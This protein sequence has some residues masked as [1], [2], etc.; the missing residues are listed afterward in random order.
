[1]IE[2]KNMWM[3]EVHLYQKYNEMKNGANIFWDKGCKWHPHFVM[4]YYARL[5]LLHVL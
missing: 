4:S 2:L 5:M 3:I 1:L